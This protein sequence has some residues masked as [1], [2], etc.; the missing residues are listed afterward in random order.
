MLSE[1]I[2]RVR[3]AEHAVEQRREEARRQGQALLDEAK[4]AGEAALEE[5]RSMLKDRRSVQQELL[6]ERLRAEEEK[7]RVETEKQCAALSARGRRH[8]VRAVRRIAEEVA[9]PWPL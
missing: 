9:A 7:L 1:A 4:Q 8:M 3:A 2:E 6:Q 5:T